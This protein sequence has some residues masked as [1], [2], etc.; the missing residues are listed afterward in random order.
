MTEPLVPASQPSLFRSFWIAG[1]ESSTHI[2]PARVRLDMIAGIEHDK[3][4]Y[5]DYARL[6]EFNILTARDGL[7][8]HLVDRNG[9]YDFA[10]F[11]PMLQA[12]LDT[13]I[14]VI[15]DLCHYG[16]PDDVDLLAP[17][18]VDRFAKFSA[19]VA[20]FVREHTDEVP[21]YSPMNE[22]N[23]MVWG[24]SEGLLYPFVKNRDTEIKQHLV[25]ATIASC[26]AIW[27]VDRR[28]RFTYP[29]PIINV[30]PPRNR[31]DLAGTAEQYRQSQYEAWDMIAGYRDPHLGGKPEYL[32]ILGANFYHSN[33]WE[34]E[35]AGR[36]RWED[37]PRDDRWRPLHD[38]LGEVWKRYRR[39]LYLAETSHFGSGRARWIRETGQE[40]CAAWKTG[41]PLAGA[42]LYPI[43][44]RFDWMD[45]AHWHNSGLWDMVSD[46]R[47]KFR[48]VPNPEYAAAF[49]ET[50]ERVSRCAAELSGVGV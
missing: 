21:F 14:Q 42:C 27:D 43:L 7:R 17:H 10:S 19:A 9:F 13:G 45:A 2:S 39:P 12:S 11:E 49:L 16:W 4:I 34:I 5:E 36:L 22:I 41:T 31:P 33:Q 37:E 50:Q 29:E 40:I 8:W 48:R 20:R 38:M 15:W 46:D 44:D 3:K 26:E 1:F 30:L 23:F 6:K 28:A 18:F 35:G 25:R 32:D 24:I 47:E